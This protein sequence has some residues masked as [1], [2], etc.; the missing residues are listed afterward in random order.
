MLMFVAP[1]CHPRSI[2]PAVLSFATGSSQPAGSVCWCCLP[3]TFEACFS[4]S[5]QVRKSSHLLNHNK[6]HYP[7]HCKA[8]GS[9]NIQRWTCSVAGGSPGSAVSSH[10]A[11]ARCS[12][13]R[14]AVSETETR[15][16]PGASEQNRKYI[17]ITDNPQTQ[18]IAFTAFTISP[19]VSTL[20][21]V[22]SVSSSMAWLSW[23]LPGITPALTLGYISFWP[24]DHHPACAPDPS[25]NMMYLTFDKTF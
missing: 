3:S 10:T 7:G 24:A 4:C 6:S 2:L 8:S 1:Q 12:F 20:W 19:F 22:S 13:A 18:N 25:R 14:A 23:A 17:Y 16:E 15:V 11:A 21:D 9:Y 5:K